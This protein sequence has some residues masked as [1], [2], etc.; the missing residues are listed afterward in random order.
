[1]TRVC[2]EIKN[3][4]ENINAMSIQK[5]SLINTLKTAKKAKVASQSSE[6]LSSKPSSV[7]SKRMVGVQSISKRAAYKKSIA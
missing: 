7:T 1:V 2:R 5:K 6:E 4:E 3:K